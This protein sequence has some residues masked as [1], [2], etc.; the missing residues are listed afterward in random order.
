MLQKISLIIEEQNRKKNN[1]GI[2]NTVNSAYLSFLYQSNQKGKVPI[3]RKENKPK[4]NKLRLE[5]PSSFTEMKSI[6]GSLSTK[7]TFNDKETIMTQ[8]AK[9]LTK[10]LKNFDTFYTSMKSIQQQYSHKLK[11]NIEEKNIQSKHILEKVKKITNHVNKWNSEL[12]KNKEYNNDIV[13]SSFQLDIHLKRLQ[14][15][16]DINSTEITELKWCI[17][18]VSLF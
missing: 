14:L 1:F 2:N 11:A 7:D 12:E 5:S 13:L 16:N 9:S 8:K 15:E 6:H 4:D 17:E 3:F 18:K 10:N